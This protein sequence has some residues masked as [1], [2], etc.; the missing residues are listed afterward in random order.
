MKTRILLLLLPLFLFSQE[1]IFSNIPPASI[2]VININPEYCDDK[3]LF[4]LSNNKKPFSFVARFEKNTIKDGELHS[5]MEM[6]SNDIGIYYKLRF[7]PLGKSLEVALLMPKKIIGKYSTTTIDTILAYLFSRD[8]DFRFKIFDSLNEDYDSLVQSVKKINDERFHFVI[9]ILS[10]KDSISAL[11]SIDVPIYIPTMTN[12]DIKARSNI[13]FGGIDYESQINVLMSKI[14]E[15]NS[16]NDNKNPSAVISYND[17][18]SLGSYLGEIVKSLNPPIFFEEVITNKIAA[19]F[20]KNIQANQDILSNSNIFLNTPVVKSGLL[21]SQL[22]VS[23]KKFSKILSTQVNYNPALLS[24]VRGNNTSNV[25]IANS[26]SKTE[27]K[28]VE[29]GMLLSS[30]LQYDWVNYSTALGMDL[31]L[32]DMSNEFSRY[33]VESFSRNQAIYNINLYKIENGIF[34]NIVDNKE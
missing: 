18:S 30:D 22:D 23:N 17:D 1:N 28:L 14:D 25:I 4:Q 16:N 32:N 13:V 21:L 11:D 27:Q 26:I 34:V 2:E 20:S 9:A 24:L 10:N 7:N 5:L 3:C 29:Y 19:N 6:Y 33:F 31:F 15:D 8:I 12:K